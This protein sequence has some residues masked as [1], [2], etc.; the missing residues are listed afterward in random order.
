MFAASITELGTTLT[1]VIAI[2]VA[3]LS[4]YVAA[5]AFSWAKGALS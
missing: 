3:G 5:R 1:D 4:V 2:G